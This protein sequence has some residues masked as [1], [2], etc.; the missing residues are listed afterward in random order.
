MFLFVALICASSFVAGAPCTFLT[1][2]DELASLTA[3]GY[4]CS[5]VNVACD[6]GAGTCHVVRA[7]GM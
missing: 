3:A 5:S 4:T 7:P 6:D 2:S 1:D